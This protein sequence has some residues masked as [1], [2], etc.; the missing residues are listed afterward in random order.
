MAQEIA[1]IATV[2]LPEALKQLQSGYEAMDKIA[3]YCHGAQKKKDY[4]Q[5]YMQS[6]DYS[7]DALTNAAYH[8]NAIGI[9]L[10]QFLTLQA[11]K[12][13][14]LDIHIKILTDVRHPSS[15]N[16]LEILLVLVIGFDRFFRS[17]V[18][19]VA[20]IMKSY[21]SFLVIHD[22]ITEIIWIEGLGRT[23][24]LSWRQGGSRGVFWSA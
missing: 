11:E 16:R 10:T 22:H 1:D 8:V 13:E 19:C 21:R 4:Q 23:C 3:R 2:K 7:K 6:Q 24:P 14:Q 18:D 9:H 20:E 12:V 15:P 17:F 5:V